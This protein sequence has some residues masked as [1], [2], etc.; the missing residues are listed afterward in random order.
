[1]RP[2]DKLSVIGIA[3]ISLFVLCLIIVSLLDLI[4]GKNF[5][6]ANIIIAAVSATAGLFCARFDV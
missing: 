2:L 4:F 3:F 5:T 6:W 1:M